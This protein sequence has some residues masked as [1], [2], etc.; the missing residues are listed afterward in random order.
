MLN[1]F[2]FLAVTVSYADQGLI[3]SLV[4]TTVSV[5][6]NIARGANYKIKD[7]S[8]ILNK[9]FDQLGLGGVVKAGSDYG[10]SLRS[11]S[12]TSALNLGNVLRA[13]TCSTWGFDV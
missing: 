1:L 12:I 8:K 5:F 10:Q 11:R 2:I 3:E 9:R 7:S 6:S 4:K 13:G